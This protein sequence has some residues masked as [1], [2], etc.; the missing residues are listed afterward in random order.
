[1]GTLQI[2]I[3]DDDD[4]FQFCRRVVI[5]SRKYVAHCCTE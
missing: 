4:A 1:M 2:Y 5:N 3:D